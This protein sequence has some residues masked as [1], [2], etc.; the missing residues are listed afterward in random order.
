MG[1]YR[2]RGFDGRRARAGVGRSGTS[3]FVTRPVAGRGY[4]PGVKYFYGE[5]DGE[6]FPTQDDLFGADQ[7]MDFIMQYGDQA[8]KAI[9]EMMKNPKNE[10]QSE[11]LEQMRGLGLP[12]GRES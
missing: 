7:L 2:T 8:L 1:S 9:E 12:V 5:Y 4:N 11:L 6:E 10:A 3:G